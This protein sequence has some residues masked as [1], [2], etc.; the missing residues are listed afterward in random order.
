MDLTKIGLTA[1][2]FRFYSI[3]LKLCILPSLRH[4]RV[5]KWTGHMT[6][7]IVRSAPFSHMSLARRHPWP[8]WERGRPR[9]ES[10]SPRLTMQV[11]G[12]LVTARPFPARMLTRIGATCTARRDGVGA[13]GPNA[14][15]PLCRSDFWKRRRTCHQ[16]IAREDLQEWPSLAGCGKLYGSWI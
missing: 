2:K 10:A 4:A 7:N 16:G 12:F 6:G 14:S 9:P 11:C 3:R 5:R 8:S 1:T 15:G 13:G